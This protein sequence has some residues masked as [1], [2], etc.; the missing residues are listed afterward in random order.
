MGPA[1][2]ETLTAPGTTGAGRRKRRRKRLGRWPDLPRLL[3]LGM[4]DASIARAVIPGGMIEKG[5]E[6]YRW[7]LIGAEVDPATPMTAPV[8]RLAGA[9]NRT[10]QVW[11]QKAFWADSSRLRGGALDP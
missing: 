9:E 11:L 4:P 5:R 1:D 7:E 2:G 3:G 10:L 6:A 8:L